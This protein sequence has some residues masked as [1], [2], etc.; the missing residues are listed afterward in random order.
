VLTLR[1]IGKIRRGEWTGPEAAAHFDQVGRIHGLR[2]TDHYD[3]RA[4]GHADRAG[5]GGEAVG[6]LK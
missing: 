1:A 2:E 3:P 5:S 6:G 4:G